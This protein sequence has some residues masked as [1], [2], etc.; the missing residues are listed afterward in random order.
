MIRKCLFK[1]NSLLGDYLL[2][3]HRER[4]KLPEWNLSPIEVNGSFNNIFTGA[5]ILPK[6]FLESKVI[7][8][9]GEAYINFSGNQTS[10]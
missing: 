9:K 10:L 1:G 4:K 8:W 7:D 3:G 5:R 2:W 6:E